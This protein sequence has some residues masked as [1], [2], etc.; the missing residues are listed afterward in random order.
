MKL[1]QDI[2]YVWNVMLASLFEQASTQVSSIFGSMWQE[3]LG[4][5]ADKNIHANSGHTC[6]VSQK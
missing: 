1:D 3:T 6:G 4:I 5:P 2:I